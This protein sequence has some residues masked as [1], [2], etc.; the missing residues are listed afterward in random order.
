MS[1]GYDDTGYEIYDSEKFK[2]KERICNK[3]LYILI[4]QI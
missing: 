3:T 2:K 1:L 4:K